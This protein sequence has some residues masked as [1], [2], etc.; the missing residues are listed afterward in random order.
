MDDAPVGYTTSGLDMPR[1]ISLVKEIA[2]TDILDMNLT[3]LVYASDGFTGVDA[4]IAVLGMYQCVM[5]DLIS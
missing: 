5:S 2:T 4:D 1:E 3:I